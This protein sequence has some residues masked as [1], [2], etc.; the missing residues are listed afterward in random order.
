MSLEQP[1][2]LEV[3]VLEHL[4]TYRFLT[5]KQLLALG[6]TKHKRHLQATLRAL[7][8]IHEKE[9]R[10]APRRY[11]PY[12]KPVVEQMR[13]GINREVGG[14]KLPFVYTLTVQGAQLLAELR[15]DERPVY[16]SAVP[17]FPRQ[18]YRHRLGCT[19][20]HIAVRT[21]AERNHNQAR[22]DFY[23]VDFNHS[24]KLKNRPIADTRVELTDG[25][26]IKPDAV[27]RLTMSDQR[28]RLYALEFWAG[29]EVALIEQKLELYRHA[30]HDGAVERTFAFKH[31]VQVLAVFQQERTLRHVF[32]RLE[33][34]ANFQPFSRHFLF[35]TL[36]E[37]Q[38]DMAS[39][40]RQLG[41]AGRV[42]LLN[43]VV[44]GFVSSFAWCFV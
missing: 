16:V 10:T 15:S 9:G 31:G 35:A 32:E 33:A 5:I 40:W 12:R 25:R 7:A 14:G 4:A 44:L 24:R 29:S 19:D 27:F 6:A 43:P 21:W 30:L 37:L 11:Q 8:G 20:C 2:E 23:H 3:R 1:N 18:E 41:K 28:E 38:E 42:S 17:K 13:F 34:R 39:G 36:E 22:L 26:V